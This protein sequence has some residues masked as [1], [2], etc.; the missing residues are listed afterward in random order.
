MSF[1]GDATI[2]GTRFRVNAAYWNSDPRIGSDFVDRRTRLTIGGDVSL[3]HH[4]ALVSQAFYGRL[5]GEALP[6]E[7]FFLGG[8]GNLRTLESISLAGTGMAFAR[9]DLVLADDLG[10]LLHVP[11]P[12]WLP[13]Q[14]GAFAATGALWGHDPATGVAI[15]IRRNRPRASEWMPEVGGG[16]AWRPGV[17]DPQSALRFEYAAPVGAHSDGHDPMIG[18]AARKARF[19][20]AL[21]RTLN[22]LPG[23]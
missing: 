7:A 11:L 16:I 12:L 8:T 10:P 17:P 5:R 4:V 3:G 18:G 9:V 19:T 1:E 14:A 21:Q 2:P 6:Q 20:I 15:A 13:L 23:R 22:L